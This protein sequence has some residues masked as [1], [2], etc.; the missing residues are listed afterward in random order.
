MLWFSVSMKQI[1]LGYMLAMKTKIIM[2][3]YICALLSVCQMSQTSECSLNKKH[4]ASKSR[5]Y[6]DTVSLSHSLCEPS[7]YLAVIVYMISSC[8]SQLSGWGFLCIFLRHTQ[9]VEAILSKQVPSCGIRCP[10]KRLHG[11]E[12]VVCPRYAVS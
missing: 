9:W 3:H 1:P 8:T 5:W 2:V 7:V 4:A 10:S 6:W 11:E 12:R